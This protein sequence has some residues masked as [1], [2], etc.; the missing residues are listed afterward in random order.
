MRM[1]VT[2]RVTRRSRTWLT[3]ERG[4]KRGERTERYLVALHPLSSSVVSYRL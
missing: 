4:E 1:M 3:E 2:T